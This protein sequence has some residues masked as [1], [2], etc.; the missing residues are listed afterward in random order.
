MKHILTT[1]LAVVIAATAAAADSRDAILGDLCATLEAIAADCPGET[2]IALLTDCGDTVTVNN[3]NK[4]PLMSVFKLHQAIALCRRF[5]DTGR[6][7]DSTV[8]IARASLNDKTWSPMLKDYRDS[9]I[10]V[11]VRQLLRYTLM[12]SDNNASNYMFDNML[13]VGATDSMIATV[14][15]RGSFAL[16]VTEA[17]MWRDH[18]LCYDN[19]STPLSAA[20]LIDRLHDDNIIA[21]ADRDFI[22]TALAEC[23]TGTD[24][25]VAPLRD[26]DGITVAHKTGSGFRSPDGILSAH[27]DV[28]RV[29]LPDGRHY[30]L[31][32]LIKD[33]HGTETDAARVIARISAAVHATL[34]RLYAL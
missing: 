5:E 24:R 8:T 6:S 29:T 22:C 2:G 26:I 4:Y 34:T 31:A 21:P 1:L 15:P 27:N 3:E 32:V 28:G 20:L 23:K 12:Q 25:I 9:I 11:S 16:T 19:R 33:Y 18:S 13:G 14:V 10:S 7:L 17:D 30:T